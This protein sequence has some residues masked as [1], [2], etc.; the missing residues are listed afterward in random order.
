MEGRQAAAARYG[1]RP[2][3][4]WLGP[5][6][7]QPSPAP[8]WTLR[9]AAGGDHSLGDYHGKPVVVLFFLGH[10]CLHCAK[11]VQAFGEAAKDFADAGIEIIAISSDDA[12][13]LKQSTRA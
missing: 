3:L 12:D 11:Q 9:D 13:G 10:G 1:N 4:D 7:W 5:L 6:R 2:P 8:A